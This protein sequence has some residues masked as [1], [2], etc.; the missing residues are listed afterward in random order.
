MLH[1]KIYMILIDTNVLSVFQF[2]L[3]IKVGWYYLNENKVAESS[4]WHQ[5]NKN[6]E[7]QIWLILLLS[8]FIP[9][10]S[11]SLRVYFFNFWIIRIQSCHWSQTFYKMSSNFSLWDILSCVCV[12]FFFYSALNCIPCLGFFH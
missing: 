12:W 2:L 7:L 1:R 6:Y 3:L 9:L 4:V 5:Q 10:I 8:L 11:P